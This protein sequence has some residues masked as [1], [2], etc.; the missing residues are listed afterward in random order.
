MARNG[1]GVYALP[2]GSTITNGDTSDASDI[3]VPLADIAAD[4][5]AARPIVAGGTG[6]TSAGAARTALGLAIGTNVQ[7]Y[8]ASLDGLSGT[9][10]DARTALGLAIGTDVQAFDADLSAFA[11]KTAPSGA[12]VG[13]T[14]TQTL[15]N[16]TVVGASL[17][18]STLNGEVLGN[19]IATQA[20]AEGGLNN[21][22]LMTPLTTA[23]AIAAQTPFADFYDSGEQVI[24]PG[25]LLTLAHGLG[26][27]PALLQFSLIC[28]T[29]EGGYGV[30]NVVVF[31]PPGMTTVNYGMTPR[32]DA[33]N[34][35]IR[36][37][38]AGFA[39]HNTSGNVIA[40][41]SANW[42]LIVK[43]WA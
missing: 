39:F 7:A 19:S 16:K 28:K 8:S 22:R 9:A 35:S 41:T 20:Q 43:A 13:T 4:L 31:S 10:A 30:N 36:Y 14:D 38:T 17:N 24:T 33:T 34:I 12:V 27:V 2:P 1:S 23:Q 15:T 40:F 26:A 11:A 6:S 29:A 5:N 25:G 3:N 21:V 42:R 32:I 37:G 18:N